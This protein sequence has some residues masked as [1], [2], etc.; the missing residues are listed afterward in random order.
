[1]ILRIKHNCS[2]FIA[3]IAVFHT[4]QC[5]SRFSYPPLAKLFSFT[6]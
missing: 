5:W 4:L 1:L 2:Q 3:W 6:L